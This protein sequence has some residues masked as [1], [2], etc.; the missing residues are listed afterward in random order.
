MWGE[1]ANGKRRSLWRMT[2]S[3]FSFNGYNR[4]VPGKIRVE[5]KPHIGVIARSAG[6]GEVQLFVDGEPGGVGKPELVGYENDR[7]TLGCNNGNGEF[8]GAEFS[9]ILIFDRRLSEQEHQQLGQYLGSRYNLATKYQAAPPE[10]LRRSIR[11]ASPSSAM[12][13]CTFVA[14]RLDRATVG[15]GLSSFI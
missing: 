11:L 3:Q 6:D 5:Q 1:E 10:I 7:I 15:A 14:A 2:D 8:A 4:D 9:E 12:R 13:L